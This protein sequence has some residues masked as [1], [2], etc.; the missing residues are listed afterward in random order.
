MS[1]A[2][3]LLI[4]YFLLCVLFSFYFLKNKTSLTFLMNLANQKATFSKE[5][6]TFVHSFGNIFLNKLGT[7]KLKWNDLLT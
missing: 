5:H 6:N 4:N 2:V 3:F 1:F 7:I